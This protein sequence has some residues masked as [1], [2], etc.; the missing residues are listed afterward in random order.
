[1]ILAVDFFFWRGII[2]L[3]EFGCCSVADLLGGGGGK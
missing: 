2:V 3:L 1:M